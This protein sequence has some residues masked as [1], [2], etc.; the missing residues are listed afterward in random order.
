MKIISKIFNV[1]KYLIGL[2]YLGI[3][4]F[5]IVNPISMVDFIGNIA[6][7]RIFGGIIALYG[8]FRFYRTYKIQTGTNK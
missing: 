2:L 8:G 6:F 5:L 4:I 1:L 7:I 3:G